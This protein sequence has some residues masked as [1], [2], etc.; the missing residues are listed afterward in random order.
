MPMNTIGFQESRAIFH[1]NALPRRRRFL[2]QR[3]EMHQAAQRK[4]RRRARRVLLFTIIASERNGR[5]ANA[6]PRYADASTPL[7]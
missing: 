1:V 6:T 5:H 2:P 7:D 4:G 3:P